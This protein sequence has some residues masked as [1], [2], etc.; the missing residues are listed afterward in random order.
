MAYHDYQ[1]TRYSHPTDAVSLTLQYCQNRFPVQLHQY[2]HGDE[3]DEEYELDIED[4]PWDILPGIRQLKFPP[5]ERNDLCDGHLISEEIIL[6]ATEVLR[7]FVDHC[8]VAR[9]D[10][11]V[12]DGFS[13]ETLPAFSKTCIV[14]EILGQR[15]CLPIFM[16]CDYNDSTYPLSDT[17]VA[18]ALGNETTSAS[19]FQFLVEQ[20][21]FEDRR[22]EKGE[23]IKFARHEVLPFKS[24]RLLGHGAQGA[25]D[26]I[27]V[28][29]TRTRWARKTWRSPNIQS[30][31]RFFK[32]IDLLKRLDVRRHI[33]EVIN[34]YSRGTQVGI[35]MTLADCDLAH[36]LSLSAMER[37]AIITDDDLRKAYGCL[38][39][40]LLHMHDMN[41]RHKDIKP[42]NVLVRDGTLLFTDFGTSKDYSELTN[43]L[44]IGG[45]NTRRYAAPEF[46]GDAN[47][48]APADV[49]ALGL[50]L[51]SIWS[52]LEGWQAGSSQNFASIASSSPFCDNMAAMEDWT[53]DRISESVLPPDP[54]LRNI[55]QR[56]WDLL[57][58]KVLSKM[59]LA[60]PAKRLRVVETVAIFRHLSSEASFCTSCQLLIEDESHDPIDTNWILN[61]ID[62]SIDTAELTSL[63]L[64]AMESVDGSAKRDAASEVIASYVPR[65]EDTK[66]DRE[67]EEI[68][69]GK[70][71][72]EQSAVQD[73]SVV[74]EQE[75][76]ETEPVILHPQDHPSPALGPPFADVPT[77]AAADPI[78]EPINFV[79]CFQRMF[80]CPYNSIK[81]WKVS[82]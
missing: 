63:E 49:F 17:T 61:F 25:V 82:S 18:E 37:R 39:F 72:M 52:T 75:R 31:Q 16:A 67:G 34:T 28:V 14:L 59:I 69:S 35:V 15:H 81:T 80:A 56:T 57:I 58:L 62:P 41:I 71:S 13:F 65:E 78:P 64:S 66:I 26:A 12:Y 73:E 23:H 1:V 8:R 70:E 77:R 43:S 3:D 32:E 27:E 7:T 42:Q 36:V 50:V 44:T 6:E 40:S 2:G 60:E 48:Q 55:Y 51:L 21:R 19:V 68:K 53:R 33:I 20:S 5:R 24:I 9:V 38:S 10:L 74:V 30:N 46:T 11:N 47:H 22:W 45:T 4:L 29:S 76:P 54:D 79:D